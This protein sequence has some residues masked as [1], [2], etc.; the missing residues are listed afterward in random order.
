MKLNLKLGSAVI[1]FFALFGCSSADTEQAGS[2]DE[3]AELTSALEES[4]NRINQACF[5]VRSVKDFESALQSE[6]F[7]G[8]LSETEANFDTP[9]SDIFNFVDLAVEADPENINF[10]GFRLAT[11]DFKSALT[12]AQSALIIG[13]EENIYRETV[14]M[15]TAWNKI[16]DFCDNWTLESTD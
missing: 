10:Q 9:F 4:S 12:N 16:T 5:K 6:I 13:N 11:I 15:N 14:A 2:G 7:S 1:L 8:V 3:A